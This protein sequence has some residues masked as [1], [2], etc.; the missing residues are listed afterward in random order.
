MSIILKCLKDA[1]DVYNKR[2]VNKQWDAE[3]GYEL[4][5]VMNMISHLYDKNTIHLTESSLKVTV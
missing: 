1:E 3:V 2:R 5:S 4:E